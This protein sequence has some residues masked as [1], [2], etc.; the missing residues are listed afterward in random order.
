MK[1]FK[2]YI[3]EDTSVDEAISVSTRLKKK[4]AIRRNKAKLK[5]GRLRASKRVASRDVIKK[6]A[7]RAA[8]AM[9]FKR[10]VKGKSKGE[11]SYSARQSFEK[12]INKRAGAIKNIARRLTP[13]VRKAELQRRL[14]KRGDITPRKA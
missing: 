4:Q 5:L 14:G 2:D 11:L 12:I 3:T 9:M 10:L 13:K 7:N 6:R 8:R 1:T